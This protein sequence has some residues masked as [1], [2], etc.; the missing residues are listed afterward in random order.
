M[1]FRFG[2][3]IAVLNL[4]ACNIDDAAETLSRYTQEG[5]SNGVCRQIIITVLL[6][7][8]IMVRGSNLQFN[9]L[10]SSKTFPRTPM[11]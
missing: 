5:G 10:N 8:A 6:H 3:R 1:F 9:P 11:Y 2:V 7:Q 4:T